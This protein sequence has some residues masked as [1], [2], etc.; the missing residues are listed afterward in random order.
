MSTAGPPSGMPPMPSEPA[1]SSYQSQGYFDV[2]SVFSRAFRAYGAN[3]ALLI[4]LSLVANLV[5]ALVAIAANDSGTRHGDITRIIIVAVLSL[6]LQPIVIIETIRRGIRTDTG[7]TVEMRQAWILMALS[8]IV[9]EICAAIGIAL[10]LILLIV[11]GI[12][13]AI[14]WCTSIP[15][16]V[17]E[18]HLDPFRALGRSWQL[19]KQFWGSIFLLGLIYVVGVAIINVIINFATRSSN[20]AYYLVQGIF[21]VLI[22]PLAYLLATMIYLELR[23]LKG[24]PL[25]ATNPG[26]Y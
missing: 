14:A 21:S 25:T 19:T 12:L 1:G 10:G 5:P 16:L 17:A 24:E 8:L 22:Y 9:L 26:S 23:K 15:S 2:G 4:G 18:Q 3:F 6:L 11:P 20:D 13:L 7:I